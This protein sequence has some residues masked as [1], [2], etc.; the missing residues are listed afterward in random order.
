MRLIRLPQTKE[1][2][3]C[4]KVSQGPPEFIR[5]F[6]SRVHFS[7]LSLCLWTDCLCLFNYKAEKWTYQFGAQ[8]YLSMGDLRISGYH[9]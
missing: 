7:R 4:L 1:A 9:F 3:I 6:L 2:L 8:I 5:Y